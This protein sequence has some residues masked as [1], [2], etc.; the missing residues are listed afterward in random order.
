ML[1]LPAHISSTPSGYE[2]IINEKMDQT[3]CSNLLE[4]RNEDNRFPTDAASFVKMVGIW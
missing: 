2:V 4:P 3:W 1:P